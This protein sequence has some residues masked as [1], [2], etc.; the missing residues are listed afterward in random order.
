MITY[1]ISVLICIS[2]AIN[3]KDR[4]TM[5][6]A[7][8]ARGYDVM[9]ATGSECAVT[10]F[11]GLENTTRATT[12]TYDSTKRISYNQANDLVTSWEARF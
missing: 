7:F 11:P 2:P 8:H 1:I 10:V 5:A 4:S 9:V 6:K 12:W 3:S